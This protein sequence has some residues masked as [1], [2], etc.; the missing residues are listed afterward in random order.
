MK[1]KANA[2]IILWHEGEMIIFNPGDKG[3]LPEEVIGQYI[4]SKDAVELKGKAAKP[5]AEAEVP[6]GF[7]YAA[8]A[9]DEGAAPVA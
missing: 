1:F 9:A 6:A 8:P 3:D 5:D 2:P 4:G 7:A